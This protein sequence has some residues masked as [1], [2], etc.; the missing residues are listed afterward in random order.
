MHGPHVR[1]K[2]K[3]FREDSS[4]ACVCAFDK[5]TEPPS[6]SGGGGST[7]PPTRR[8]AE[9][10][11]TERD[12][13]ISVA[14]PLSCRMSTEGK[15]GW[16]AWFLTSRNGLSLAGPATA[17]LVAKRCMQP[18]ACSYCNGRHGNRV[19]GWLSVSPTFSHLPFSL[20]WCAEREREILR[21][22]RAVVPLTQKRTASTD[23]S[24]RWIPSWES[25]T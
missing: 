14:E 10:K 25:T 5:K 2:K 23:T 20:W 16:R 15:G 21:Y 4:Q 19:I 7:T 13:G 8:A 17:S 18:V 11:R 9:I 22:H 6:E 1:I 3:N 12:C 24:R